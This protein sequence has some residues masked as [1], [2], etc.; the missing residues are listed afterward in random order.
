MR[1]STIVGYV[2]LEGNP[3]YHKKRSATTTLHLTKG[4]D[5]WVKVLDSLSPVTIRGCCYHSIF[6]GFLI[7]AD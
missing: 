6:S 7:K 1:S 2:Y 3:L 5:V 4:D